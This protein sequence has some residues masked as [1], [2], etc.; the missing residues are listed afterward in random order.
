MFQSCLLLHSAHCAPQQDQLPGTLISTKAFQGCVSSPELCTCSICGL[1]TVLY[2]P[3][4]FY[5]SI[6]RATKYPLPWVS[7][8]VSRK[9]Q[10]ICML[11]L[12]EHRQVG[13]SVFLAKTEWFFNMTDVPCLSVGFSSSKPS[14]A[15]KYP[16]VK[17]LVILLSYW[18][19]QLGKQLTGGTFGYPHTTLSSAKFMLENHAIRTGCQMSCELALQVVVICQVGAGKGTP[20]LSRGKT[21]SEM[22]SHLSRPSE[23][24]L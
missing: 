1:F 17:M 6:S 14:I 23:Y 18:T 24:V 12:S 15:Y 13:G 21:C 11:C 2:E 22:L 3:H 5:G 8:H 7:T 19:P 16:K 4:R 9:A 20:V 10:F